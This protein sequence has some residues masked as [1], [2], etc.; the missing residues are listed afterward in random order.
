M[1][2]VNAARDGLIV[3]VVTMLA[4][5]AG[6]CLG[7]SHSP[8]PGETM[9]IGLDDLQSGYA[10]FRLSGPP[11]VAV[12]VL[13]TLDA[14]QEALDERALN[15]CAFIS[16]GGAGASFVVKGSHAVVKSHAEDEPVVV[17]RSLGNNR[18]QWVHIAVQEIPPS[19]ALPLIIAHSR[20]REWLDAG[21]TFDVEVATFDVEVPTHA[22]LNVEYVESGSM[23]CLAGVGS[24]EGTITSTPGFVSA[25]GASASF[26]LGS[27]GLVQLSISSTAGHSLSLEQEGTVRW[28][29]A[30]TADAGRIGE[31]DGCCLRAGSWRLG[32]DHYGSTADGLVAIVIDVPDWVAEALSEDALSLEAD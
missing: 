31:L 4:S 32:L 9:T 8:A 26:E 22:S 11:G 18:H 5:L 28:A 23:T 13:G 6:G 29:H 30:S 20:A 1:S 17:E 7:A 27:N 10:L 2:R 19:G 12:T 24:L 16:L 15:D 3:L 21:A 25:S 14:S